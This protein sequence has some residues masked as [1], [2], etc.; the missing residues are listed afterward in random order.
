MRSWGGILFFLTH[1]FVSRTL[2]FRLVSTESLLFWGYLVYVERWSSLEDAVQTSVL[3]I[4]LESPKISKSHTKKHRVNQQQQIHVL[5][6]KILIFQGLGYNLDTVNQHC[7]K[8]Y[9]G[10]CRPSNSGCLHKKK[11][12]YINQPDPNRSR[13]SPKVIGM[14]IVSRILLPQGIKVPGSHR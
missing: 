4:A 2:V 1:H 5:T 8:T 14:P 6:N 12:G 9:E 10:F 13:R 3:R 7:F 11:R